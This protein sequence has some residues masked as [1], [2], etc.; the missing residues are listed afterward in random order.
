MA[1]AGV[2]LAII[3]IEQ[4]YDYAIPLVEQLRVLGGQSEGLLLG[5]RFNFSTCLCH[6]II[7]RLLRS[8]VLLDRRIFMKDFDFN[9]M[10]LLVLFQGMRPQI[11]HLLI[12]VDKGHALAN[13]FFDLFLE[14]PVDLHEVLHTLSVFIHAFGALP[15]ILDLA[16][17]CLFVFC[18]FFL[19][20]KEEIL[21]ELAIVHYQLVD[22]GAMHVNAWELVGVAI[23]YPRHSR[24]VIGNL[25]G[26][27]IYY[28][29][30]VAC[31]ILQKVA[32]VRIVSCQR[33]EFDKMLA[34]V[35]LL[36]P[37]SQIVV[38]QNSELLG[39]ALDC[40]DYLLDE[41]LQHRVWAS[42][43]FAILITLLLV[44]I[45]LPLEQHLLIGQ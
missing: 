7:L 18:K 24:E 44:S 14:I 19:N 29:I 38:G 1:V 30:V 28:Q 32:I 13:I 2:R 21:E 20:V 6:R 36:F 5:L 23:D 37:Q 31:N 3:G 41:Y 26:V 12:D 22:D 9:L 15:L 42:K 34:V 25:L 40:I 27:G 10:D 39:K 4:R 8:Q 35:C 11:L 33:S 45:I 16:L 43:A 17:H